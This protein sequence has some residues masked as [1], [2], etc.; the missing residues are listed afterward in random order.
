M[1][2]VIQRVSRASVD[3]NDETIGKIG[4]GFLVL[5]GVANEER[6]GDCSCRNASYNVDRASGSRQVYGCETAAYHSAGDDMG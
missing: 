5:L 4:R 3:V 2:A 1:K 6:I